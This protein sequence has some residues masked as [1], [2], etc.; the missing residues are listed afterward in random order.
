HNK[1]K[2]RPQNIPQ[3]HRHRHQRGLAYAPL[4]V[5]TGKS[6]AKNDK[7]ATEMEKANIKVEHDL[8][9]KKIELAQT[10]YGCFIKEEGVQFNNTDTANTVSD[11]VHNSRGTKAN[12]CPTSVKCE[13]TREVFEMKDEK[14]ELKKEV[15]DN[16]CQDI[17]NFD[18]RIIKKENEYMFK[19][20]NTE[21]VSSRENQS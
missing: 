16:K 10:T 12:S 9:S 11:R 1:R 8:G 5:E 6:V 19:K 2:H 15:D 18:Q 4:P 3:T 14:I 21:N 17:K 7:E 13:G 20:E